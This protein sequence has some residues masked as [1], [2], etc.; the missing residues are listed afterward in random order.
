MLLLTSQF[1][2]LKGSERSTILEDVVKRTC[3][4]HVKV[5]IESYALYF[6]VRFEESDFTPP[7][8][9]SFF[10]WHHNNVWV[11]TFSV[12]SKTEKF[13]LPRGVPLDS[14]IEFVDIVGTVPRSPFD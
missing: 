10:E 14:R 1:V 12:I 3:D 8:S 2:S 9:P 5:D 11:Q 6:F 7:A 4:D 13:K